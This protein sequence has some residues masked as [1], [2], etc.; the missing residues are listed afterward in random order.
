MRDFCVRS[1]GAANQRRKAN[2]RGGAVCRF[3]MSRLQRNYMK[4]PVRILL[5]CVLSVVLVVITLFAAYA[6]YYFISYRRIGDTFVVPERGTN[7]TKL[8]STTTSFALLSWN[9]GF[10]AYSA[11]YSFFMD[12]GKYSRA[13]SEEAVQSNLDGVIQTV[14]DKSADYGRFGD[15]DFLCFQEVD[16]DS[17]RSYKVN[18]HA[19]LAG[20]FSSYWASYVQNYDSPYLIYPFNSPH[21]AN[22]SGMSTFCKYTIEQ[23]RRVELP[24]ESGLK[25]VVDLDRCLSVNR[26]PVNNGKTLV[27]INLHLTAYSSDGSIATKQLEKLIAL[28]DEEVKA[29]NYVVC[30]GDFNKDLKGNAAENYKGKE[31]YSWAKPF[32]M[33]LLEGSSMKLVVP[34]GENGVEVPSCRNADA[35]YN[36][37][38]FVVTLDGFLVSSNLYVSDKGVIDT[39]FKYSDHNPVYLKFRL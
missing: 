34:E 27:L 20:A 21:G 7:E 14:K 5:K 1:F 30:A 4:K 33:S 13:F 3:Q 28:C 12:G 11:D 31:D 24:V 39:G 15:F 19:K 9:V 36:P 16:F 10:G 35:P 22:K 38:Q 29:G 8:P 17:T 2:L 32:D 6:G 26:I 25:K 18:E 37:D 23:T